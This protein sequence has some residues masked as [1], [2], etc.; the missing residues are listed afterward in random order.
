MSRGH[1]VR[2][3][4]GAGST[5]VVGVGN[6][7]ESPVLISLF[8]TAMGELAAGLESMGEQVR[9]EVEVRLGPGPKTDDAA[10]PPTA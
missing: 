4:A 9:A 10:E 1:S 2:I 8:G 3:R 5:V 7:V 6:V